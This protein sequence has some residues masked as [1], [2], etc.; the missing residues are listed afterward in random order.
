MDKITPSPLALRL[1]QAHSRKTEQT[2]EAVTE[3]WREDQIRRHDLI[4]IRDAEEALA[5]LDDECDWWDFG[6]SGVDT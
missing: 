6:E 5:A 1:L 2:L 3:H 4:A